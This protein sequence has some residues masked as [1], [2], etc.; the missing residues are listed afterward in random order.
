MVIVPLT[1]GHSGCIYIWDLCS[2]QLGLIGP[3]S[4]LYLWH[5]EADENVLVT[6]EFN[7]NEDPPEARETKWR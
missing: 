7:W 2:D 1:E 5:T 6:F 3:F 4:D